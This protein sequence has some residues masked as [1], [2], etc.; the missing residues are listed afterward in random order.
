MAQGT[1]ERTTPDDSQTGQLI[2][3]KTR[4]GVPQQ[5]YSEPKDLKYV[6]GDESVKLMDIAPGFD[7]K[8][9]ASEEMFPEL[10]KPVQMN[11]DSRGRLWVACMPTYPQWKPGDSK[12]NDRILIFEDTNNDGRAD[13]CKVFYDQLH[14]PTGF[15]F[16]NGGVL[17]INQPRLVFLKDTD[18]DDKADQITHLYDG[19]ASDDTHH[20][21][22]AF[23][24][25]PTGRLHGLEGV[26][27][28]TTLESPYGAF[29]NAN[30]PGAYVIEPPPAIDGVTAAELAG[31]TAD[32]VPRYRAKPEDAAIA[33]EYAGIGIEYGNAITRL[34]YACQDNG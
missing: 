4:F 29:R 30:T 6:S 1:N 19:W 20:T 9:F 22:G 26:S 16:V 23:E 11:F 17:V 2:T 27:M 31:K 13:T 28:S 21:M 3:P 24:W 8:L 34:E 32:L 7:V 15:E 12:P 5:S 33:R 10:A 18:G 25:S 14:C